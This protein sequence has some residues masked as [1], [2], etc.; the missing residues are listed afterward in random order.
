MKNLWKGTKNKSKPTQK[1]RENSKSR[2]T[3]DP[4]L[5]SPQIRGQFVFFASLGGAFLFP[6]S[7]A[8]FLHFFAKKSQVCFLRILVN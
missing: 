5:G 1:G 4:R 2:Q 7:A 6:Y 3:L 8:C